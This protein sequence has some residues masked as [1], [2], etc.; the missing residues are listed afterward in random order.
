M[1]LKKSNQSLQFVLRAGV[2]LGLAVSAAAC[3]GESSTEESVGSSSAAV[4]LNNV[5][6]ENFDNQGRQGNGSSFTPSISG[7]QRYVVFSS[8]ANSWAPTVDN[9][10]LSDVYLKDR[11]TGAITLVSAANGVVGNGESFNASVADNGTVVFESTATNLAAGATNPSNKILARAIDGT[12]S[13]VD[14]SLA[15]QANGISSRPKI[16]GNGAFAIFESDAANLVAG[17]TNN[18]TD[19]FVRTLSSNA[20]ARVSVTVGNAQANGASFL[21]TISYDGQVVA[22]SSDASNIQFNDGNGQTDVF[23]RNLTTGVTSVVSFSTTGMGGAV[24]NGLSTAPQI[25]GNG[26]FVSFLSRSTNW[27]AADTNGVTDVF[28]KGVG[29]G[30]ALS[31]VSVSSAGA[32]ANAE[33]TA[34]AISYDGSLVAF[35]SAA[36]NLVT[37]DTNGLADAFVRDRNALSTARVDQ[38]GSTQ[39]NGGVGSSGLRFSGNPSAPGASFLVFDSTASNLTFGDTNNVSDVFSASISL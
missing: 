23:A 8:E 22:F 1:S 29:A 36:S 34:S 20:V 3:S 10:G 7:N 12:I 17:D 39:A 16:S 33:S 30:G 21:G 28:V 6:R 5:T 32:Q 11:Q 13:R 2:V 27:D 31:R 14:V 38:L 18:T 4:T 35:V 24:G 9:N 15:G 19:V 37:G 25:S 26:A